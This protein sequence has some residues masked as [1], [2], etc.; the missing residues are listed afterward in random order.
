MGEDKYYKVKVIGKKSGEEYEPKRYAEID[1]YGD[2]YITH[3]ADE[4]DEELKIVVEE[5]E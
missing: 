3:V 5:T 2:I 4:L 1:N